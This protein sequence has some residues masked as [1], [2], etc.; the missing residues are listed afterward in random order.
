VPGGPPEGFRSATGD[1]H[2]AASIPRR[3]PRPSL[4]AGT[5]F[6]PTRCR[7]RIVAFS[8]AVLGLLLVTT[9]PLVGPW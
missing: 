9:H 1:V 2:A 4:P 8:A 3:P 5:A 7:G 6:A